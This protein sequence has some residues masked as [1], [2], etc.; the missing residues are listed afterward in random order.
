V[1]ANSLE[2]VVISGILFVHWSILHNDIDRSSIV[3]SRIQLHYVISRS[4]SPLVAHEKSRIAVS[5]CS[6]PLW[7]LGVGFPHFHGFDL[8]ISGIV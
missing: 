3:R 1:L 7:G 4:I 6:W 5:G 8:R 2:Q